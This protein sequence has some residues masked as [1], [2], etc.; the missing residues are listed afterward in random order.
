MDEIASVLHNM[1]NS[2]KKFFNLDNVDLDKKFNYCSV[3]LYYT[4]YDLKQRSLLG[5]HS[6]YVYSLI[7]GKFVNTANS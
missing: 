1:L 7:T 6:N 3:I 4:G 2:N 5:M